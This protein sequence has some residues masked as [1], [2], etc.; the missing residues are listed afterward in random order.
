MTEANSTP[1]N[2]GVERRP[3]PVAVGPRKKRGTDEQLRRYART[4][5]LLLISGTAL[6][7][8]LG[9][10]GVFTN[11]TWANGALSAAGGLGLLGFGAYNARKYL[12]GRVATRIIT[13]ARAHQIRRTLVSLANRSDQGTIRGWAETV[14]STF[15]EIERGFLDLIQAAAPLADRSATLALEAFRDFHAGADHVNALAAL[16]PS[17]FERISI[18]SKGRAL[19]HWINAIHALE[20]IVVPH[21][22]EA[23]ISEKAKTFAAFTD[24][25]LR[26]SED[27]RQLKP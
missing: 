10:F 18:A 22:Y 5:G 20:E 17:D 2:Q 15:D 25:H 21:W 6:L 23:T 8:L 3:S 24:Q 26:E 13:E 12:D 9:V 27:A 4:A 1:R 7:T 14:V 19:A 16:Q 11:S